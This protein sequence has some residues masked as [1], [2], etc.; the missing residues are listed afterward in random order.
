MSIIKIEN[1]IKHIKSE[2][3][4]IYGEDDRVD[5]ALDSITDACDV[6]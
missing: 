2:C 5:A 1:Q 4:N 3:A 6:I